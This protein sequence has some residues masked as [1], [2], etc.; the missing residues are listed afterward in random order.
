MAVKAK[1][2]S[3]DVYRNM[4]CRGNY[5]RLACGHS[6]CGRIVSYKKNAKEDSVSNEASLISNEF[7]FLRAPKDIAVKCKPD[8]NVEVQI[9]QHVSHHL[10]IRLDLAFT[11]RRTRTPLVVAI[12]VKLPTNDRAFIASAAERTSQTQVPQTP[13][14]QI[15][16]KHN[17]IMQSEDSSWLRKAICQT[18]FEALHTTSG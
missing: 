13:E 9:R 14:E 17:G 18:I 16:S 7:H 10:Q 6:I 8:L 1:E 5:R 4:S 12:E 2:E 11:D 3:K 15:A